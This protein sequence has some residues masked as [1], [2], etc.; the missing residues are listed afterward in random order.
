ML[1]GPSF[2]MRRDELAA[3][4][5]S[6]SERSSGLAGIER[7]G[8]DQPKIV[9][10]G[11]VQCSASSWRVTA[12][13]ARASGIHTSRPFRTT[14][15]TASSAVMTTRRAMKSSRCRACAQSATPTPRVIGH[16]WTSTVPAPA[17]VRSAEGRCMYSW[18]TVDSIRCPDT[19][20]KTLFNAAKSG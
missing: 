6:R 2:P 5:R 11:S 10:L 12:T 16:A 14:W 17:H 4:N 19:G 20:K 9:Q 8:H 13:S 15:N 18:G 1:D 3:S 7:T